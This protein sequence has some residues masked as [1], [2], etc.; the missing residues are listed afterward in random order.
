MRG[1]EEENAVEIFDFLANGSITRKTAHQI[2]QLRRCNKK[3]LRINSR[4]VQRQG[5]GVDCGVFATTFAVELPF[6]ES[7][8]KKLLEPNLMS[9]HLSECL[10]KGEF[11]L[12]PSTKRKQRK[13]KN[14]LELFDIYC[15]CR[16]SFFEE[17]TQEDKGNFMIV[18][19]K[20]GEGCH[21]KCEKVHS[22]SFKDEKK[23]FFGNVLHVN[24]HLCFAIDIKS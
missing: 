24:D 5:N 9:C 7:P 16:K 13:S 6:G 8:E 15:T 18:C 21:K 14:Y 2:C 17:D 23:Q 12:L 20:C 3:Q 19:S 11:F 10:K 22:Q 4:S 1:K